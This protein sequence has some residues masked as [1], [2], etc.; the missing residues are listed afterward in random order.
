MLPLDLIDLNNNAAKVHQEVDNTNSRDDSS[1]ALK[2]INILNQ[3]TTNSIWSSRQLEPFINKITNRKSYEAVS[4]VLQELDAVSQRQ[5]IILAHFVF[6]LQPLMHDSDD[7]I[8]DLAVSL[9]M[10]Y[11]R[12]NPK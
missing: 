4:S 11:L 5:S 3:K 8:R 2:S 6:Y 12:L 1:S 10:R 9:V 7:V